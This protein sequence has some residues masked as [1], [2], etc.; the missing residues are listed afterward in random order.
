[1]DE[2]GNC[3]AVMCLEYIKHPISVARMVMEKTPHVILVGDGALQFAL[4]NG[5]KKENPTLRR[6]V[7]QNTCQDNM[8]LRSRPSNQP[9]EWTGHN[10][11]P[12]V[13]PLAPCLPLRG[14]VSQKSTI[15]H[16][17]FILQLSHCE[18]AY[19]ILT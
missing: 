4:A 1:M 8:C 2:K 10:K 18:K 12:A 14:S 7:M 19:G 16:W 13:P 17:K 5:F 9:L 6:I 15:P 3:G 11:L